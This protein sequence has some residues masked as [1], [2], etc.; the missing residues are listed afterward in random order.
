[1][2]E[3]NKKKKRK[4]ERKE[5]KRRVKGRSGCLLRFLIVQLSVK[6]L[7]A[8]VVTQFRKWWNDSRK[9]KSAHLKVRPWIRPSFGVGTTENLIRKH[10]VQFSFLYWHVAKYILLSC[11]LS[12]CFRFRFYIFCQFLHSKYFFSSDSHTIINCT[13]ASIE[14]W[15]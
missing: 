6:I 11:S 13:I 15:G 4:G 3:R 9:N 10:V 2:E 14:L 8:E 12:F 1:M 7:S 5:W